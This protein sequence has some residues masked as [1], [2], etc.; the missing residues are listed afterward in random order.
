MVNNI[1]SFNNLIKDKSTHYHKISTL[2]KLRENLIN[3]LSKAN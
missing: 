2:I 1:D 3:K